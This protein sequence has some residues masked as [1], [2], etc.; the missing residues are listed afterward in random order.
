MACQKEYFHDCLEVREGV[1]T[2]MGDDFFREDGADI[3][4]DGQEWD[5]QV[6]DSLVS[7]YSDR[8]L[9]IEADV[10]N[11]CL[12]ALNVISHNSGYHFICGLPE[13][14]I[15]RALLWK[16]HH[17]HV[18]RR[19]PEFPSWSWLGWFGRTEY[20]YWV[21]DMNDYVD[22]S[23]RD[24]SKG[25][26]QGGPPTKRRR[27]HWFTNDVEHPEVA[28][29]LDFISD[30]RHG[31][32]LKLST[33]VTRC[34]G[35]LLQRSNAAHRNLRHDSQQSKVAVGDHWTLLSKDG[36]TQ[37]RNTTGEHPKFEGTDVCFRLDAEHS[38]L[39][40]KQHCEVELAFIHQ[41]PKVRDSKQSDKW[42]FDMI[43]A[44]VIVRNDDQTFIRL[45][46]VLLERDEWLSFDPKPS[47]V[48]FG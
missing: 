10:L 27:M 5:M 1:V 26:R 16:P 15:W 35:R 24:T 4:L 14:D 38:A 12:G 41:W 17:D 46:A 32:L 40:E 39:I 48:T 9:T 28:E 47:T 33:T 36:Q 43:S 45:A 34:K 25:D 22:V 19:R 18:L 13:E 2:V 23:P 21:G 30:S 7:V 42:C 37:I 44:L 31:S 20:P 8:K 11:A 3:R 29:V 6:Y